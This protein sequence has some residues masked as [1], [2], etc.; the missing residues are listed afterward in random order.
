MRKTGYPTYA[1]HVYR[2]VEKECK[3]MDSIYGDYIEPLVGISGLEALKAWGLVETC[4]VIG[5]RQLYV[6]YKKEK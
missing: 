4:G 6:L 3:D 5:G 2:I 1:D